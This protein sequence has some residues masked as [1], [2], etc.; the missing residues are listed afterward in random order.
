MYINPNIIG[1]LD[2][3]LHLLYSTY[4]NTDKHVYQQFWLFIHLVD[5]EIRYIVY[6]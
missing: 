4:N 2:T 5:G 6:I 3:G 1:T